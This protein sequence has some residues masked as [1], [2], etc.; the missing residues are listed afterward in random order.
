M[1]RA[2]EKLFAQKQ[3][4]TRFAGRTDAGVHATGQCV[5]VLV[6][7]KIPEQNVLNAL[8]GFL[9]GSIRVISAEYREDGLQAQFSA[10]RRRYIYNIYCGPQAPL[11]LADYLWSLDQGKLDLTRMRRAAKMLIGRHD[12]SAVCA[13]GSSAKGKE[14]TVYISKLAIQR[15]EEWPGKK[16]IAGMLISYTIEADGFLYHMVRNI[17]AALVDIG[18]GE[19]SIAEFKEVLAGKNRSNLRSV[20]APPQGLVLDK[21]SY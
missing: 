21:V 3:I 9:P 19:M 13:A 12:F 17:V 11:Y 8:N 20:T 14:R 15:I 4:K 16:N 7:R 18:R 2:L 5:T 6:K 1:N 10:K